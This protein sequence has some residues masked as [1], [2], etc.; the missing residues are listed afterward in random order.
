M[1]ELRGGGPTYGGLV[2]VVGSINVDVVVRV[3]RLPGP[4]ETVAGG[5]LERHGGGKGANQAVAAARAGARVVLVG[6]VGD[7]DF[8]RSALQELRR[9]GIDTARVCELSEHAT[10]LAAITVDD[11]G[12]NQ[13]AVASGANQALSAA[14][15]TRALRDVALEPGAVLL[16]TFELGDEPL[17]AAARWAAQHDVA[18]VVLNPAPA[19]PV[20]DALLGAT[21]LLTPNARELAQLSGAPDGD[22]RAAATSLSERTGAP[23]I[24]TV[25]RDGALVASDGECHRVPAPEVQAVDSTGAGDAFNGALAAALAQGHE[26]GDSVARAVAAASASVRGRGAR[27]GMPSRSEIDR[28]AS[29]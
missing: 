16:M 20:A 2:I 17:E 18:T 28:L 23:V 12:E 19:R 7:D 21:P 1:S 15:V 10:G 22:L 25:G 11:E 27:A 6:A 5:T 3:S 8:G 29:G 9:E 4:G 24:V 14:T 26:L 13:I